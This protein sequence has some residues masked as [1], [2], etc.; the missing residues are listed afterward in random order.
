MR[1]EFKLQFIALMREM[2]NS[3]CKI[4]V[5]PAE[6]IIIVGEADTIILHFAFYILH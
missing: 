2:Q 4:N 6:M 1:V 3:E 5:F